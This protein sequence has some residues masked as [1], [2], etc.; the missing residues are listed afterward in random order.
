[1]GPGFGSGYLARNMMPIATLW[2]NQEHLP[3]RLNAP[4]FLDA[5][6]Y[7]AVRGGLRYIAVYE[8]ASVETLQSQEYQRR[9][10]NTTEWTKRV[11]PTV[12][13]RNTVRNV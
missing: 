13:G 1:M 8:L 10:Q 4:G 6:R 3:E 9:I 5:A 7:E 12:I 2:Y 11:S